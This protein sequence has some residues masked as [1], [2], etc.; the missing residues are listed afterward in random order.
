MTTH[1]TS[2]HLS[3]FSSSGRSTSRAHPLGFLEALAH[4]EK[5]VL[6]EPS[7]SFILASLLRILLGIM[8]SFPTSF[9]SAF[10][11][12]LLSCTEAFAITGISAGVNT[13]TGERP[14]RHDINELYIS[15]PPWDLFV[16][17]LSEFQQVNQDDPLSYYQVAGEKMTFML[18]KKGC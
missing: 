18:N 16:L 5:Q 11:L 1:D 6:R 13:S 12:H 7:P 8:W 14:F 17:A 9:S 4:F 2:V 15:G 10:F 3:G